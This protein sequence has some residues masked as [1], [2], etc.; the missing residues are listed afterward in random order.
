MLIPV[1]MELAGRSSSFKKHSGDVP[2]WPS[3]QNFFYE[4]YNYHIHLGHDSHGL[5]G[6]GAK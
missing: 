1:G 2:S 6:A 3:L 5:S 4:E